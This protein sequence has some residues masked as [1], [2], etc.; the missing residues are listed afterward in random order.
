MVR[1]KKDEIRDTRISV[2]VKK[3]EKRL[4][5]KLAKLQKDSRANVVVDALKLYE[6]RLNELQ[7][8]KE[9]FHE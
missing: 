2:A 7:P 1:V 4:L 3:S 9:L 5:D 8:Q 6:I